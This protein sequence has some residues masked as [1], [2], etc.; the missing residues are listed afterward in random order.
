M[1][2]L[3]PMKIYVDNQAAISTANNSVFHGRTKHFK[4]KIYFI[5]EAQEKEKKKLL[6]YIAELM[7]RLEM[8]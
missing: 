3:E 6:C 5:K 8:F 2:Q 1:N 4:I 7:I